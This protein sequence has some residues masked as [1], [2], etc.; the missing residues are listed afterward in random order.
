MEFK[1]G[2]KEM[3]FE[4]DDSELRLL[5]NHFDADR[6]ASINFEEFVQAVRDPLT[7]RRVAL[8]LAAYNKL[9]KVTVE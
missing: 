5:F 2:M 3:S 6:S 9:D 8:V 4:L 7:E 1:K